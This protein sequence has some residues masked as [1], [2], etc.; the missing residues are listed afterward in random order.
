MIPIF[1]NVL[2]VDVKCRPFQR[3]LKQEIIPMLMV[4]SGRTM[5]I[6]FKRR[7]AIR[8]FTTSVPIAV[9]AAL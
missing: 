5:A 1:L 2:V 6:P 3:L 9:R 8:A 7:L 4:S